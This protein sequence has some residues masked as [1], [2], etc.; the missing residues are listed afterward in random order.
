M[1][2]SPTPSSPATSRVSST[3]PSTSSRAASALPN[4]ARS[5]P[6]TSSSSEFDLIAK[7]FAPLAVAP[8]AFALSDDAAVIAP[9]A[10]HDLVVTTDAIVAGVD[11]FDDDPP[12]TIAKKAL[13]VNLSDLAAKGAE[14][15]AYL[16]T[17][18]L[19][20][21]DEEWLAEFAR[22]LAQDQKT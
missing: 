8:G 22:G 19:P 9:R 20:N 15:F 21:V 11:F 16:L 14:P 2:T 7:Y 17:L 5:R 4:S 10:G 1:S 13:R 3:Q 18:S 12:A 6:M